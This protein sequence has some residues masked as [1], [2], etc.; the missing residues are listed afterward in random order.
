V[1]LN[2]S[3]IASDIRY[4]DN[5]EAFEGKVN[6]LEWLRLNGASP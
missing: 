1:G 5:G 3:S 2:I 4:G 6:N